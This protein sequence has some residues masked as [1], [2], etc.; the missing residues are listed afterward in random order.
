MLLERLRELI[1]TTDDNGFTILH[2]WVEMYSQF[3][4][5]TKDRIEQ[6]LTCFCKHFQDDAVKLMSMTDHIRGNNPLHHT[7]TCAPTSTDGVA[8]KLV[9][10]CKKCTTSEGSNL[11]QNHDKPWLMKNKDGD[12]PLFLAIHNNRDEH[13]VHF[14]SAD[15]VGSLCSS[16]QRNPFVLALCK[17]WYKLAKEILAVIAEHHDLMSL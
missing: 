17:K 6:L 16:D 2:K 9:E 10:L 5:S 13:A 15:P 14:L 8:K 4:I 7:V 3:D 1:T 12:T 11:L